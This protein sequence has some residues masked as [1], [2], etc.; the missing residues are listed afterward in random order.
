MK[1]KDE[2]GREWNIK[3]NYGLLSR[4]EDELGY[5][6]LEDPSSIPADVKHVVNLIWFCVKDQAEK[7]NVTAQ[8]FGSSLDGKAIGDAVKCIIEELAVF[9]E[10]LQPMVSAVLRKWLEGKAAREQVA[11]ALVQEMS[12]VASERESF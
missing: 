11:E 3:F 2:N 1:F 5:S 10:A 9:F 12:C 7:I 8:D 4:I 6:I